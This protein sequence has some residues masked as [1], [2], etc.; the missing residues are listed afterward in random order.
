MPSHRHRQPWLG[1]PDAENVQPEAPAG[2]ILTAAYNHAISR[3]NLANSKVDTQV[4][5]CGVSERHFTNRCHEA[6][7]V[8]GLAS[9]RKTTHTPQ[10]FQPENLRPSADPQPQYVSEWT[11]IPPPRQLPLEILRKTGGTKLPATSERPTTNGVP[12][13]SQSV[14]S[15]S[16]R[17]T[18]TQQLTSE[19][20]HKPV[21]PS[22]KRKQISA[23]DR[24]TQGLLPR[25]AAR[26]SHSAMVVAT[27]ES[28]TRSAPASQSKQD[29]QSQKERRLPSCLPCRG[30]HGKCERN[31]EDPENSCLPCIRAGKKC[32]FAKNPSCSDIDAKKAKDPEIQVRNS[33]ENPAPKQ[34]EFLLPSRYVPALELKDRPPSK[35]DPSPSTWKD[36]GSS[37]LPRPTAKRR[38]T[39]QKKVSEQPRSTSIIPQARI[40]KN[41]S[42]SPLGKTKYLQFRRKDLPAPPHSDVATATAS[43]PAVTPT[44]KPATQSRTPIRP[45]YS[46]LS[47]P[48]GLFH[49]SATHEVH[50]TPR[51]FAVEN[52]AA[53][54]TGP[55]ETLASLDQQGLDRL[56][57]NAL[58]DDRFLEL[59]KKIENTLRENQVVF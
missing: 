43:S 2:S 12:Q 6:Q 8:A 28:P 23:S 59:C 9:D 55:L 18:T 52:P 29:T 48:D 53:D 51:D 11:D 36:G 3:R 58:K 20:S 39:R 47:D 31:P 35:T 37:Q 32:S 24:G 1:K 40:K 16:E 56:I 50:R 30:R 19:V 45:L 21:M 38:S 7:P 10:T 57:V 5:P 26:R 44:K 46:E 13:D 14:R 27:C 33:Q 49:I 15:H 22:R 17:N 25:A 34:R 4:L 42:V 41:R 54:T